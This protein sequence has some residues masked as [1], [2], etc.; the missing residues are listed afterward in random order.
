MAVTCPDSVH[1]PP[2]DRIVTVFNRCFADPAGFNTRL[3]GGFPEPYYRPAEGEQDYHRVEFTRDYPASALHE[4]AHWCVAGEARR[5]L[6]DYGYW[7]APDGR[8]A[9][10]QAEFERVEVVPQALEWIFACACSLRFRVSADNLESGLGPSV[11][12]KRAIWQQVQTFCQRGVNA[13][14]ET[15]ARALA[16]EFGR[17]DPLDPALYQLTDLS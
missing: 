6:P 8:S 13:R 2:C 12:F 17:P 7:Y 5:R 11:G 10:Q 9:E 15:F 14:A 3:C 16:A 1:L 4:A